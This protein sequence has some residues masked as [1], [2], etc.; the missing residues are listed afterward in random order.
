MDTAGFIEA[1][2][3]DIK[4]ELREEIKQE[5]LNELM[6]MIEK[7]LHKNLFT[8]KEAA[9][10]LRISMGSLWKLIGEQKI[11]HFHQGRRV[12]FRQ[13]DLDQYIRTQIRRKFPEEV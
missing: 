13:T 2:R 8:T 3:A 1:L 5:L 12:L 11:P 4:R 9:A 6:P 10:Y 7:R